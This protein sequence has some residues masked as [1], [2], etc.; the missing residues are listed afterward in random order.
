[1]ARLAWEP[2]ARRA[3]AT[4]GTVQ[5]YEEGRDR[6]RLGLGLRWRHAL[7]ADW[8]GSWEAWLDS[9]PRAR[10]SL[11]GEAFGARTVHLHEGRWQALSLAWT[12]SPAPQ[13]GRWQPWLGLRWESLRSRAGAPVAVQLDS[14]RLL[15]V[16]QPAYRQADWRMVAGLRLT[17][18]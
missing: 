17:M 7:P 10:L 16:S 14:G 12:I 3:L 9:G 4:V 6:W 18:E 5:G 1:G 11:D 13:V 8:Q 2:D 15:A